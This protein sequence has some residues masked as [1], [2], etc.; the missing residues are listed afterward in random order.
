MKKIVVSEKAV[1]EMIREALSN[2][3]V[4]EPIMVS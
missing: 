1:R 2:N 3:N 4:D